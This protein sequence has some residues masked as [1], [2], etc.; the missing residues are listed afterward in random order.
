MRKRCFYVL[1]V[2]AIVPIVG[3][4]IFNQVTE[5]Q[6]R[7]II[8]NESGDRNELGNVRYEAYDRVAAYNIKKV[9]I[10]NDGV[11]VSNASYL[12]EY[13]QYKNV[14]EN[15]DLLRGKTIDN[16]YITEDKKYAVYASVEQPEISGQSYIDLNIKNKETGKIIRSKYYGSDLSSTAGLKIDGDYLKFIAYLNDK[17]NKDKSGLK[18]S[19]SIKLYKFQLSNG[20]LEK[21]SVV[22]ENLP[23]CIKVIS[24]NEK[25]YVLYSKDDELKNPISNMVIYDETNGE[26]TKVHLPENLNITQKVTFTGGLIYCPTDGGT[27]LGINEQ[28]KAVE[29]FKCEENI[30]FNDEMTIYNNKVYFFSECKDKITQKIGKRLSVYS[31]KSNKCLYSGEINVYNDEYYISG[32]NIGQ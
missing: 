27:I 20:K 11:K 26:K 10:G 15:K 31:L 18:Q 14:V 21:Q 16:Q 1:L 23:Q 5:A 7:Y 28:G 32:L 25:V 29:K 19:A 22:A 2:V 3:W 24:E 6:Q 4:E 9:S 13:G 17:G 30:P 8:T 12:D